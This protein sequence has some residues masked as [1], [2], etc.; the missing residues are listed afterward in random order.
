VSVSICVSVS[1]SF[2]SLSL[3]LSLCTRTYLHILIS[4]SVCVLICKHVQIYVCAHICICM[5]M[6]TYRFIYKYL[7][8]HC[9]GSIV[10]TPN[11]RRVLF[12]KRPDHLPSLLFGATLLH[13]LAPSSKLRTLMCVCARVRVCVYARV[14]VHVQVPHIYHKHAATFDTS[15][16]CLVFPTPPA[17]CRLPLYLPHLGVILARAATQRRIGRTRR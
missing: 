12:Q 13:P 4:V 5:H 6:L 9:Q 1:V 2:L 16:F 3:S 7:N 8:V 14:H 11:S 17:L 10:K 15:S